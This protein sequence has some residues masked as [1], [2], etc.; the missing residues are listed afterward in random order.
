MR[1][2]VLAS[3]SA[4]APPELSNAWVLRLR[5]VKQPQETPPPDLV[6]VADEAG[7]RVCEL[8]PSW[9]WNWVCSHGLLDLQIFPGPISWWWYTPLSEKS[10]L[11]SGFIGELYWLT[12][13]R[14]LMKRHHIEEVYWLGDDPVV[15]QAA[16]EMVH[17]QGVTFHL[18]L[19][20]GNFKKRFRRSW[21]WARRIYYSFG[22]VLCWALL[23][24]YGFGRIRLEGT[25]PEVVLYSRFPVLWDR[26]QGWRERIYGSWPDCLRHKGHSFFYAAAFSG[27]W[28]R[29]IQEGRK[30]LRVCREQNI[31]I[32]QAA[33]SL[34]TLIRS[35][36]TPKLF[37]RY[38]SWRRSNRQEIWHYDGMEVSALLRRELDDNVLSTEIPFDRSLAAA[39]HSLCQKYP[40]VRGIFLPFEHQ[41]MERA[42]WS[43]AKACRDEILLVGLQPG[44]F[45]QSNMGFAFPAVEMRRDPQD[46][47]KAPVPDILAAY[48]TISQKLFARRLGPERA[49]LCGPLRYPGLSRK[50]DINPERFR[51]ENNL[52]AGARFLLVSASMVAEEALPLLNGAFALAARYPQVFLL[53]KF[54][55][56]LPLETEVMRLAQQFD[57]QRYRIFDANLYELLALSPEMLTGGSSTAMEAVFMDCMPLVYRPL[58]VMGFSPARE[59]PDAVFFWHSL[60]D[61]Q[62]AFSSC[63][64]KDE[65]YQFRVKSWPQAVKAHLYRIDGRADE[66]LYEFIKNR[67][68]DGSIFGIREDASA[69][70]GYEAGRFGKAKA[71][72]R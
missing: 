8:F 3:A 53:F 62:E 71:G 30:L 7:A 36:L 27:S 13:V 69:A 64:A 47:A 67:W 43:G 19:T 58:G 32:S 17:R 51:L 54:H 39:F 10:P 45:S 50:H 6:R 59:T 61:L 24:I 25:T 31:L 1:L 29:L 34:K 40:S 72:K 28:S 12:L 14:L 18:K 35:H 66:R 11:R 37:Y 4:A 21:V 60:D 26:A 22:Q 41:P 42:V 20:R 33:I 9:L 55:Y 38:R 2:V 23:K 70:A 46:A 48:G 52:P 15:A 5:G 49:C 44:L 65:D 57:C 68:P 56:H 16:R 63:L